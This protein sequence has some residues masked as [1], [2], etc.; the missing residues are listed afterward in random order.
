MAITTLLSLKRSEIL[1]DKWEQANWVEKVG[2][3]PNCNVDKVLFWL[4]K[5]R[6]R[7]CTIFSNILEEGT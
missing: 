3:K 2:L 1:E 7:L 5:D 6:M 4:K